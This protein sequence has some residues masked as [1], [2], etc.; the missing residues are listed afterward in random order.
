MLPITLQM[1]DFPV[2]LVG[3]GPAQEK[4]RQMLRAAGVRELHVHD[5]NAPS[6]EE[7]AAAR[8][9]FIA[10]LPLN[11]AEKLAAIAR[12]HRVLVNVEDVPALCD[13]HVPA[14]VRRGDLSIAISTAGKSPALAVLLRRALAARFDAS[15]TGRLAR[16]ATLRTRLRAAGADGAR[17]MRASERMAAPWLGRP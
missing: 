9:L 10:G 7:I 13:F 2:L 5:G 8:L 12:C 1:A 3:T 11:Q 16:L 6:P 4:R 15:W 17:V 14:L